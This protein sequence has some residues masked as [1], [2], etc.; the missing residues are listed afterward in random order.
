MEN[1]NIKSTEKT[2][3]IQ[4]IEIPGDEIQSEKAMR[5]AGCPHSKLIKCDELLIRLHY[6]CLN[7]TCKCLKNEKT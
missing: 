4:E 5:I 3:Q 7:E 6:Y 2:I 1:S